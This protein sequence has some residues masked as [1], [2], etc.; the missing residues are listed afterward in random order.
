MDE[1]VEKA[2][3]IIID[4]NVIFSS[5]VKR[6]G[7]TQAVLSILLSQKDIKILVPST[8]KTEILTHIHEISKKSGLPEPLLRNFLTVILR[9]MKV[10]DEALYREDIIRAFDFV[11]DKKD[12]PFCGLAIRNSPSI[13]LTYNK[14][15]FDADKLKMI[16]VEVLEPKELVNYMEYEIMTD[17][18]VKKKGGIYRILSRLYLLKKVKL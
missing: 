8:I 7:Y 11:K 5:L 6:E 16:G 1:G 13:I 17:K 18:K 15:H 14:R 12:S 9:D 10:V 2:Q 4:T 3:S